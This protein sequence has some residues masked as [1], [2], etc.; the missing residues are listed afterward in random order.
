MYWR[1]DICDKVINE[2]FRDNHLQSGYHK[3]LVN[4][5]IRK[6]IITNPKPKNFDDTIRKH[7]RVHYRKYEKFLIILSVKMLIPLNQIKY[8]RR[9]QQCS[10]NDLVVVNSSFFCKNKI[11]NE[12]LSSQTLELGITFFSRFDNITID[13]YITKPKSMLEWKLVAMFDKNPEIACAFDYR[14]YNQ[15]L[16]RDFYDILYR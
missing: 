1:C 2:E 7:L 8:I 14:K 5:V 4:L 10:F 16:F 9:R 15:P 3:H 6:Y 11:I 13:H 12:Q